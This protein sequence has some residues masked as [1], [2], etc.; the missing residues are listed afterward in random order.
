[1]KL[2]TILNKVKSENRCSIATAEMINQKL[3]EEHLIPDQMVF[4][5][6]PLYGDFDLVTRD[7]LEGVTPTSENYTYIGTIDDLI[8]ILCY[9]GGEYA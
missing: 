1:M 9:G 6:R 3:H 4:R 2:T 5:F 8:A 7:W